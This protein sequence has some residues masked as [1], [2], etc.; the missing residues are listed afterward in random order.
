MEDMMTGRLRLRPL[1]KLVSPLVVSLAL[2]AVASCAKR[3]A[4]TFEVVAPPPPKIESITH[5]APAGANAG[6]TVS[7]TMRGDP[8]LTAT[9]SL[10]GLVDR[11]PLTEDSGEEGVYRGS[12]L[13]PAGKPGSYDLM[14]RLE[15]ASDRDHAATL[16]GPV[17]TVL[18]PPVPAAA[19]LT[20]RDFNAQQVLKSIHF[21][22]DRSDLRADALATLEANARWIRD[23]GSVRVVIEGHCDERGTN[24]YNMA[25]GDQRANAARS[26][27]INSGIDT[28][29]IRTISYGEERPAAQG[30]NEEAWANNRRAEFALED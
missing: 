7:L 3:P 12:L 11:I 4:A 6:D 25:L 14:G 1:S 22:L 13:I 17:L 24:E 27:L 21:D 5:G 19:R 10:T 18:K 29:R 8:G 26:Y 16:A 15:L 23:H 28:A 20:A 2:L 9:A 30:S